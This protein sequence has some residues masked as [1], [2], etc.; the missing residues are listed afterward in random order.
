MVPYAYPAPPPSTPTWEFGSTSPF[1][2][3]LPTAIDELPSYPSMRRNSLGLDIQGTTHSEDTSMD[4][5]PSSS[6]SFNFNSPPLVPFSFPPRTS[7]T[8]T[9]HSTSSSST[10]CPPSPPLVALNLPTLPSNLSS[11]SSSSVAPF[12]IS[13]AISPTRPQRPIAQSLHQSSKLRLEMTPLPTFHLPLA[14]VDMSPPW[15]ASDL[16][17]PPQPTTMKQRKNSVVSLPVAPPSPPLTP[18]EETPVFSWDTDRGPGA[19]AEPI[20]KRRRLNL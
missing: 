2:S 13:G 3:S 8:S 18:S 1:F 12:P 15:S 16:A 7:T 6:S 20:F 14:D 9:R 10:P 4:P 5:F 11:P 17:G 19:E